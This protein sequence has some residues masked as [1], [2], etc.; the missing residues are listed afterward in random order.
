MAQLGLVWTDFQAYSQDLQDYLKYHV[1]ETLNPNESP[2]QTAIYSATGQ[3]NIPDPITAANIVDNQT[4]LNSLL[5]SGEF[6]S[7][8]ALRSLLVNHEINRLITQGAIGSVM[9]NN[10][11]TRLKTKLTEA[12]QD[13]N[14]ID[15]INNNTNNLF[16]SLTSQVV[17]SASTAAQIAAVPGLS[18]AFN[19]LTDV[20]LQGIQI[21]DIQS[22]LMSESLGQ[23][24][25]GNQLL[26]YSGL[27]LA[28]ISQQM[29]EA[30]RARR[31][32]TSAE[33][34]RLLR[35]T[36]QI[37]LFGRKPINSP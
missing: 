33:A 31:V 34:A 36:S 6:E 18:S 7:N 21:Q 25:Q 35:T 27:N 5:T 15:A 9:G 8:G 13:I 20:G 12:E 24:I 23:T 29:D 19:S 14:N 17:N 26:A 28:N 22:K 16:Q 3:L 10:G 30:N 4:L 37:D 1:Q 32:D 2:A 11:Q